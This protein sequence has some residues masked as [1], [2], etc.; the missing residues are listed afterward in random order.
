MDQQPLESARD[1][2]SPAAV[3]VRFRRMVEVYAT[4]ERLKWRLPA[5]AEE[6]LRAYGNLGLSEALA[7]FDASRGVAFNTF[8]EY[9][10]RGAIQNGAKAL[11]RT[12]HAGISSMVLRQVSEDNAWDRV[13][14]V[15]EDAFVGNAVA[16]ASEEESAEDSVERQEQHHLIRAALSSLPQRRQ[17]LLRWLFLEEAD[18]AEVAARLGV[19]KSRLSHLKSEALSQLSLHFRKLLRDT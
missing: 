13:L 4:K 10:V 11:Q 8:A 19:H 2:L 1:D 15:F 5:S 17:D 16:F 9:R 3:A 6:E 14:D 18:G 12:K 7:R